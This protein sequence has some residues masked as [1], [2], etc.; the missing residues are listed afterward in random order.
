MT[1][2]WVRESY[3]KR[4]VEAWEAYQYYLCNGGAF[5]RGTQSDDSFGPSPLIVGRK[6]WEVGWGVARQEVEEVSDGRAA[7]RVADEGDLV[8]DAP[9]PQRRE[10]IGAIDNRLPGKRGRQWLYRGVNR[11]VP[12]VNGN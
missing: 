3:G 12:I 9:I 2:N 6:L 4:D 8:S 7:L 5:V 11:E 1:G 10:P